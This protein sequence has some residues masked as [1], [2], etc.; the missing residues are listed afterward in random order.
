MHH[1]T[2]QILQ[3]RVTRHPTADWAAQ[4]VVEPAA[5]IEIRRGISSVTGTAGM[6]KRLIGACVD[7]GE[8]APD[9]GEG[10]A[11]ERARRAVGPI[12]EERVSG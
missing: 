7:W 5:G 10:A 12:G 1:E 9:T 4:Q 6:A 2:R 3:V 11:G 8:T